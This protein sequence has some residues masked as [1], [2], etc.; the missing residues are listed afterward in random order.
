M[1]PRSLKYLCSAWSGQFLSGTPDTLVS[2]LCTDSRKAQAGDLFFALSGERF[3]G[4]DYLREV[5]QKRVAAVVVDRAK[6]PVDDL[7]CAVLL[8][9]NARQALGQLAARYRSEFELPVV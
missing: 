7:G 3:D 2:R 4:H 5:A 8:A 1:E 9:E 6:A